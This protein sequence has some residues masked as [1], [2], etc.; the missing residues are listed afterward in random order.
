[1]TTKA[2]QGRPVPKP[3]ADG[4]DSTGYSA[5]HIEVDATE[6]VKGG[7]HFAAE[8]SA[9][10]DD[11]VKEPSGEP[12]KV[13]KEEVQRLNESARAATEGARLEM[14]RLKD[15]VT[16]SGEKIDVRAHETMG[17]L[18][19]KC[20]VAQRRLEQLLFASCESGALL[21]SGIESAMTEL[22]EVCN[23][24]RAEFRIVVNSDA[25]GHPSAQ[26]CI[27]PKTPE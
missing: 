12:R 18:R 14:A 25:H 1:M 23:R 16:A 21:H 27:K 4:V 17:E 20:E 2:N 9:I 26:P 10:A 11:S 5:K 8:A 19:G 24:S 6:T 3:V 15:W 22:N 13:T 7:G